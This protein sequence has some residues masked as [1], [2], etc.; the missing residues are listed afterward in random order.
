MTPN[1]LDLRGQFCPM[2]TIKLKRHLKTLKP[3]TTFMVFAD[4][5]DARVDFP[6]VVATTKNEFVAI[7]DKGE[8]QVY[9]ITKR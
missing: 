7:E 3:G 8:Y 5:E 2:T 9:T 6:A 4:D 1:D